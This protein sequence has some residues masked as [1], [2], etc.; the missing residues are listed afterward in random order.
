VPG[1]RP[2]AATAPAQAV[3]PPLLT[4]KLSYT[5]SGRADAAH[6]HTYQDDQAIVYVRLRWDEESGSYEDSGSTYS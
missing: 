1:A 2:A 3:T 5:F 6:S 4:G